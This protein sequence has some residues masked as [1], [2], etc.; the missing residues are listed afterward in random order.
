MN[1]CKGRGSARS[2]CCQ[3][4]RRPKQYE[5]LYTVVGKEEAEKQEVI[6]RCH[7]MRRRRRR[8]AFRAQIF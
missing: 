7:E 8:S 5:Y 3:E 6:D 2:V 1:E 4:R